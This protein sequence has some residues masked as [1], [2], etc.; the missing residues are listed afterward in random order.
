MTVGS[1]LLLQLFWVGKIPWR[2][3]WLPIPVFWPGEFRGLYSPWGCKELD[4][5]E[6]LSLSLSL[7]IGPISNAVRVG[8]GGVVRA[9]TD[10]FRGEHSSVHT[11]FLLDKLKSLDMILFV[12]YMLF[13]LKSTFSEL[14]FIHIHVFMLNMSFSIFFLF[15]YERICAFIF[16]FRSVMYLMRMFCSHHGA[17]SCSFK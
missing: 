15:C 16:Q 4:V 12:S 2:M 14:L 10:I 6:R 13:V 17:E 1:I 5:T 8:G 3:E 9:S 11:T 7:P